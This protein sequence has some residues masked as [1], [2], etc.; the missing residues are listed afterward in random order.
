MANKIQFSFGLGCHPFGLAHPSKAL[1]DERWHPLAP[2]LHRHLSQGASEVQ[3]SAYFSKRSWALEVR[4]PR[5][6]LPKALWLE[7]TR[8]GG[9]SKDLPGQ[10]DPGWGTA[11][12]FPVCHLHHHPRAPPPS[13]CSRTRAPLANRALLWQAGFTRSSPNSSLQGSLSRAWD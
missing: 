4:G 13:C 12:P 5:T 11:V 9:Q 2:H 1:A 10:A 3:F 6:T 7:L 8:F